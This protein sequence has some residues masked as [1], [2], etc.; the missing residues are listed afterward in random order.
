VA[1]PRTTG[2]LLAQRDQVAAE[3]ASWASLLGA[4]RSALLAAGFRAMEAFRLCEI[5]FGEQLCHGL[6]EAEYDDQ[7]GA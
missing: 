1:D 7:A 3:L 4:Y 5:W 2:D 6:S